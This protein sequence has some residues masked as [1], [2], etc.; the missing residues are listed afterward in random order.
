[1]WFCPAWNTLPS[2]ENHVVFIQ[3][4]RDHNTFRFYA[5]Q[6]YDECVAHV[7]EN[8]QARQGVRGRL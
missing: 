4:T 7:H 1:M 6:T 8:R 2:S 3:G 5:E